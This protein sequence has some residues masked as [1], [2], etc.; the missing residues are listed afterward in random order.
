M[1]TP[2]SRAAT[3]P[4]R[5]ADRPHAHGAGSPR[6]GGWSP[7]SR[8]GRDSRSRPAPRPRRRPR[9]G[10]RRTPRRCGSAGPPA[11]QARRQ[12]LRH[13]APARRLL[14]RAARTELR[15]QR[16]LHQ[17]RHVAGLRHLRRAHPHVDQPEWDGVGVVDVDGGP[18]L[19]PGIDA[20]QHLARGIRVADLG[21]H[22]GCG[23]HPAEVHQRLAEVP[24]AGLAGA[25]RRHRDLD[26]AGMRYSTGSSG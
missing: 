8:S 19:V 21:D 11:A 17:K 1:G 16:L 6:P 13:R 3:R 24:G 26:R 18:D 9:G 12:T 25:R 7:R 10:T 2:P 4:R 23:V 5:P 22:A 14:Q 15:Q 20:L